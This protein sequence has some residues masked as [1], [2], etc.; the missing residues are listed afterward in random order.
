MSEIIPLTARSLSYKRAGNRYS[1]EFDDEYLTSSFRNGPV[2]QVTKTPLW[3]I[4]PE[5]L[6]DSSIPESSI[7]YNRRF[8]YSLILGIVVYFSEIRVHIPLLAPVLF[9]YAAFSGYRFLRSV[10][11]MEKTKVV[12]EWGEEI[13]V[14]PHHK[15]LA[16]QRKRF[17]EGLMEAVREGRHRHDEG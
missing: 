3:R 16:D 9:L 8:R 15:Q 2:M 13:A 11:P 1:L 5:L 7:R 17:E 12:T 4:M 14:I 6:V 10:L